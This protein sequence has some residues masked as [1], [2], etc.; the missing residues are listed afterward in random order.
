VAP[1]AT[2]TMAASYLGHF[3]LAS[4]NNNNRDFDR[5]N[6]DD[7]DDLRLTRD[8]HAA[9]LS[10]TYNFSRYVGAQVDFSTHTRTVLAASR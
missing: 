5:V 4:R 3:K 2:L 10:F 7:F 8:L 9:D 6:F 1:F